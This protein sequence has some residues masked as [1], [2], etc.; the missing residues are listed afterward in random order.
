MPR[1]YCRVTQGFDRICTE[2]G[3]GWR[4]MGVPNRRRA[5]QWFRTHMRAAHGVLR[6]HVPVDIAREV[7][8]AGGRRGRERESRT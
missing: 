3:C 1:S 6:A 5:D 2:E 8:Y 4:R 7:R